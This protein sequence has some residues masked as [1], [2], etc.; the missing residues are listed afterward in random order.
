MSRFFNVEN[1]VMTY[2][3]LLRDWVILSALWCVCSLPVVTIGAATASVYYVTLKMA[4][5]EQVSVTKAFFHAFRDNLVQGIVLTVF[6]IVCVVALGS[7]YAYASAVPGAVGTGLVLCVISFLASV[8][9]LA[10]YSFP[11]MAQFSNSVPGIL[12]SAAYLAGKNLTNT[13]IMLLLNMIPVWVLL[14]SFEVFMRML[15][16]WA[17]MLPGMVAYLC[18]VRLCKIF[19]PLIASIRSRNDA[20]EQENQ[21]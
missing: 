7:A 13:V 12:K 5:R 19:D 4:R 6:F 1:P 2:F 16:I 20:E 9:C 10:L 17:F 8:L 3:A 18:S 15:P 11:F 14:F 21:E